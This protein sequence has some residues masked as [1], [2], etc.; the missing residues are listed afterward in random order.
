M[1]TYSFDD[2]T[3]SFA[4]DVVSKASIINSRKPAKIANRLQTGARLTNGRLAEAV[5]VAEG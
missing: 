3:S 2:V 5:G 4:P 1:A